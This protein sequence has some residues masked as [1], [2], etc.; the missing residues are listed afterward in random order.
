MYCFLPYETYFPLKGQCSPK[1]TLED[2]EVLALFV[3]KGSDFC[4]KEYIT[5]GLDCMYIGEHREKR[6]ASI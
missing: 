1:E 3:S 5:N 6:K 2:T 4:I